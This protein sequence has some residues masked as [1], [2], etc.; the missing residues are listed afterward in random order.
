MAFLS[1]IPRCSLITALLLLLPASPALAADVPDKGS[2]LRISLSKAVM[3]SAPRAFGSSVIRT[4]PKGAS[5]TYLGSTGI[6]YHVSD[7][8]QSGYISSKAVAEERTFTSFSRSGEVTQS[9]MA[10][11]TKGFSPE[12]ERENRK[13]RQLRYDLMDRAE[14]VSTVSNPDTYLRKFREQGKLGEYAD[15]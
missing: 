11:A 4:L 7:G 5:V 13:N 8:R 2:I 3:K 14:Q 15:E 9:D 1:P 10:A 12:V 6:F